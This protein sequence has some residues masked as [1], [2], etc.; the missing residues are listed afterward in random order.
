[1]GCLVEDKYIQTA[2]A[3]DLNKRFAD[4]IRQSLYYQVKDEWTDRTKTGLFYP[5]DKLVKKVD[6]TRIKNIIWKIVRGI[7]FHEKETVLPNHAK[8]YIRIMDPQQNHP[9]E[10]SKIFEKVKSQK[11]K[12][13]YKR[14]F[15]YKILESSPIGTYAIRLLFW[16][17]IMF[18]II[19]HGAECKCSDCMPVHNSDKK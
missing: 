5:N 13:K 8:N 18:L 9:K 2:I 15:A 16:S 10:V 4:P 17:Q 7:Y 6:L 3:S 14:L 11:D 1:M 12:G 19:F